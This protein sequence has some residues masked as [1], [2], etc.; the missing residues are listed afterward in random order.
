MMYQ[1]IFFVAGAFLVSLLSGMVLIPMIIDSC[2]KRRLFDQPNARKQHTTLVPRLG[3]VCFL[4][5]MGISLFVA[6]QAVYLLYDREPNISMSSLYMLVGMMLVYIIGMLDDVIG[7][8]AKHKLQVQILSACL[9]PMANMYINNLYGLFGIWEIPAHI[10]MPLTVLF[11]V[12]VDNA[13]N[14]IDGIDGLCSGLT[15]VALAGFGLMFAKMDM[16]VYCVMVAGL[17]GVLVAYSVFNI[18]GRSHKI[19]MGDAGSLTLGFMLAS[20]CV[21]LSMEQQSHMVYDDGRM[22]MTLSFL[23]VPCLD[24]VRVMAVRKRAHEPLFTPDRNHIHHRLIDAGYTMHQA[25]GIIVALD[26]VIVGITA[27]LTWLDVQATLVL[28]ADIALFALF[29]RWLKRK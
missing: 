5:C 17:I 1:M 18:F 13:M 10:G 6:T 2:K 27:A 4:P 15:I 14:L 16:W 12:A 7:I 11:V 3:G 25:L 26:L 21:K 22:M 24:V 9:L 29:F 28:A 19:F 20:F 8:S 23:M